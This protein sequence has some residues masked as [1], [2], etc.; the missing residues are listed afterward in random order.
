MR[1]TEWPAQGYINASF[2]DIPRATKM[3]GNFQ[4][5]FGEPRLDLNDE[6][7]RQLGLPPKVSAVGIQPNPAPLASI[8]EEEEEPKED[9]DT[10]PN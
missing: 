10:I 6:I 7:I 3:A 5:Y 1:D 8:V 9:P 4:E 2:G